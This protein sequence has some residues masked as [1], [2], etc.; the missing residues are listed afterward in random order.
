MIVS[1]RCQWGLARRVVQRSLHELALLS[2]VTIA[3]NAL[4]GC[5]PQAPEPEEHTSKISNAL[6]ISP[7]NWTAEGPAPIR[8]QPPVDNITLPTEFEFEVSGA[9]HALLVDPANPATVYAGNVGGGVFKADGS[10]GPGVD[11]AS[12]LQ[13]NPVHWVAKTDKL[14]SL[15]I[16]ALA[17]DPLDH[18]HIVAGTAQVSNF[19]TH[20]VLGLVYVTDHGGDEWTN[21]SDPRMRGKPVYGLAVRGD[22]ILAT[23]GQRYDGALLGGVFAS[24]DGGSTWEDLAD[25]DPG[26]LP[27]SIRSAWDLAVDPTDPDRYYIVVAGQDTGGGTTA[28]SGVY[29][30]TNLESDEAIVWERISDSDPVLQHALAATGASGG[31]VAVASNG[32]L[33]AAAWALGHPVYLGY[34]SDQEEGWTE[35]ETPRFPKSKDSDGKIAITQVTREAGSAE[36]IV[37]AGAEHGLKLNGHGRVR[38]EGV[39]GFDFNGDWRVGAV[40]EPSE[41][42]PTKTVKSKTKFMLHD[43]FSSQVGDGTLGDGAGGQALGT[44]GTLQEWDDTNPV[45]SGNNRVLAV[46]PVSPDIVYM[47]GDQTSRYAY[48]ADELVQASTIVRG[49]ATVTELGQIPTAQWTFISGYD[50]TL[51]HTVPHGDIRDLA[52]NGQ[53]Q[54]L[55]SSDGGVFLQSNPRGPDLGDWI[56]LNGDMQGAETHDVAVDPLSEIILASTHDNGVPEQPMPGDVGPW[57]VLTD[58]DGGVNGDGGDVR[59][60]IDSTDPSVSLRFSSRVGFGRFQIREFAMGTGTPTSTEFPLLTDDDSGKSFADLEEGQFVTPFLPNSEDTDRI[61]ILGHTKVWESVNSGDNIVEVAGGPLDGRGLAYGHPGNPDALWVAAESGAYIRLGADDP[62]SPVPF[63]GSSWDVAMS[64]S[65]PA[66]AYVSG[67]RRVRFTPD[68]TV[69]DVPEDVTGDLSMVGDGEGPG[70]L[71]RILYI[72]SAA[73][74]DRIVVAAAN[75][76]MVAGVEKGVPGVFMMQVDNPGVWT[77]IGDNLP[78]ATAYDL[79]YDAD[80]DRLYVATGGRGIWSVTGITG[81]DRPPVAHCRPVTRSADDMCQAEVTASDVDDGSFDPEGGGVTL[82]LDPAGP[83]GLGTTLVTLTVSDDQDESATCTQ[84]V[85]VLDQTPPVVTPPADVTTAICGS[86]SLVAV[87]QATATDNCAGNLVVSGQV[88][89]TNGIP[90][91]TPID[92][93]GGAVTLGFGT[94]VIQWTTNDGS[95]DASATQTVVVG[96]AIQADN[97]FVVEDRGDVLDAD[98]A[99]AAVLNSG[100]GQTFVGGDGATV[101]DIVAGGAVNVNW[102][103][104]VDGDITAVGPVSVP[105]TF[106]GAI[107]TVASVSL[108]ELPTLPTFPTPSGGNV[109]VNP[110]EVVTLAPGSYAEYTLNGNPSNPPLLVLSSGDYYFTA[111]RLFADATVVAEAG[112]RI[113]VSGE[114]VMH[115]RAAIRLSGGGGALAPVFLG[116]AGGGESFIEASFS[117]TLVAPGRTLTLGVGDDRVFTGSFFADSIHL[118]PGATLIC[119]PVEMPDLTCNDGET[120]GD[121]TDVD[122]GGPC[123]ACPDGSDCSVDDDCESMVC[124]EGGFCFMPTCTDGVQNGD[125]EGVDCGGSSCAPCAQACNTATYQAESIFHSTGGSFG[126][127]AWNI[128]ADGFVSTT[129][130][131]TPGPAVITVSALGQQAAGVLPHMVVTVGGSSIGNVF[132]ATGA[133]TDYDFFFT[134]S[135]GPEEVRVVFDNDFYAPP[136]DRN[137]IVDDFT[138]DCN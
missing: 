90:L 81:L 65:N 123:P 68:G 38:I 82:A 15:S 16:G 122:C 60:V 78:N 41:D 127:D 129:H 105:P 17:I 64:P 132:V 2:G 44:G 47:A 62:L 36:I 23:L 85:T 93:V 99:P 87:G 113:F 27:S 117:G 50:G 13:G 22:F 109:W 43:R 51:N 30:G 33:Y 115:D 42:D 21:V 106:F 133:F 63:F 74:G 40:E 91:S 124:A 59:A 86:S 100:S 83:F 92:V 96:S 3:F 120:N 55:L 95:N 12:V 80:D 104:V 94:H 138:V 84:D 114:F 131:F 79:A 6:G 29:M 116:L 10:T 126:P 56:N 61:V 1:D 54:M 14:P 66:S 110:G 67:D 24:W 111:L 72:E 57:T 89:S 103:G 37:E 25:G 11:S 4:V 35:M 73:A 101:G 135:G 77:Q 58:P 107:N 71:R 134:A 125:E 88:V 76:T 118:R 130:D 20:G 97:Q 28:G 32:R 70:Q 121:E 31:R 137:L 136:A 26:D 46:D 98:G 53:N 49:D 39:S 45:G 112:T 52:F 7:A 5:S 108:P 19:G 128:W 102:G 9:V 75:A 119:S 69:G 34:K 48:N 8:A 18:E